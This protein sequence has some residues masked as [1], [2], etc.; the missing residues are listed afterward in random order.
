MPR[1]GAIVSIADIRKRESGSVRDAVPAH[2]DQLYR[3]ALRLARNPDRARDIVQESVLRALQH[4]TTVRDPRAWLFQIVYRTFINHRRKDERRGMSDEVSWRDE[5]ELES[6]VDPLPSLMTAEDVRKAVDNLP[7]A[8]R[9]VVW[10]SDAERLRLREIAHIL[11][12]P[13]GTVASRL[14]R[15]RQELRRMLSAYGPQGVKSP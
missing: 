14:E 2:V 12:C 7:E 13:L 1:R 6:G 5:V 11:D 9:A 8:F 4:E 3:F 15:G 10:L